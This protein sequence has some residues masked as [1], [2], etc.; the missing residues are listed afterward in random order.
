MASKNYDILIEKTEI[1]ITRYLI[2]NDYVRIFYSLPNDI[3]HRTTKSSIEGKLG[4]DNHIAP[5]LFAFGIRDFNN[6]S[7]ELQSIVNR[8]FSVTIAKSKNKSNWNYILV[9]SIKPITTGQIM[10][11]IPVSS[12]IE[13]DLIRDQFIDFDH[14]DKD[15]LAEP[16]E[17]SSKLVEN[18]L[19]E[20]LD[21][22]SDKNNISNLSI[23]DAAIKVMETLKRPSK[24]L[25][26]C[27]KA[28]QLNLLNKNIKDISFRR[29]LHRT[30][31]K[32]NSP[33]IRDKWGG[34]TLKFETSVKKLKN[35][36]ETDI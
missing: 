32:S 4:R 16:K 7:P 27:E 34:Y 17:Q 2:E 18:V 22:V 36:K 19:T 35:F 33:I 5:Y 12:V 11:T 6:P 26:I 23:I 20:S 14:I 9:G 15:S 3:L 21:I 30:W 28:K 24:W 31:K 10:A 1:I 8:K 25:V 29:V 13:D